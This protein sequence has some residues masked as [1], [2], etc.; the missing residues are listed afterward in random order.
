MWYCVSIAY[1]LQWYTH[2]L[3]CWTCRCKAL[4]LLVN[5]RNTR[6]CWSR[7]LPTKLLHH[8]HSYHC[9]CKSLDLLCYNIASPLHSDR[10]HSFVVV[11]KRSKGLPLPVNQ[12]GATF[13]R[14][15]LHLLNARF[16]KREFKSHCLFDWELNIDISSENVVCLYLRTLGREVCFALRL[17]TLTNSE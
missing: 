8:N 11:P 13:V 2:R 7:V 3:A 1:Q 17:N 16:I 12:V 9:C 6:C 15:R 10:Q 14:L 4:C 5:P